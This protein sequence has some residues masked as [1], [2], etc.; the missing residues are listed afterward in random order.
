MPSTTPA[1]TRRRVWVVVAVVVVGIAVL[2]AL[3]SVPVSHSFSDEFTTFRLHLGSVTLSVPV[4]AVVTATWSTNSS[5]SVAFDVVEGNDY[6]IYQTTGS[7]GSF[8]FPA[9]VSS[10]GFV[11][12]GLSNAS[13]LVT[14][15][16]TYTAPLL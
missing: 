3:L 1:W 6:P 9:T 8:S 16:G 11:G 12:L 10:Y 13:Q 14:V 7:G 5:S 2:L 15:S 4:G